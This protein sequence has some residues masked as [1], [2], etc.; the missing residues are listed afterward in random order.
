VLN[1]NDNSFVDATFKRCVSSFFMDSEIQVEILERAQ[2]S[3][4]PGD[5][6][7]LLSV[8]GGA[9][10]FFQ[11]SLL[12]VLNSSLARLTHPKVAVDPASLVTQNEAEDWC[13]EVSNQ[14]LGR[15]KNL[16]L[17]TAGVDFTLAV[18]VTQTGKYLSVEQ[19]FD[20]KLHPDAKTIDC[21][22][23]SSSGEGIFILQYYSETDFEKMA[24]VGTDSKSGLQEGDALLF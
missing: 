1:S 22:V 12:I 4:F 7:D 18:P 21:R 11:A 10:R 20:L 13:G 17:T 6:P 2:W 9:G 23:K 19:A 14:I 5:V 24:T 3:G 16:M 15:F 8:V